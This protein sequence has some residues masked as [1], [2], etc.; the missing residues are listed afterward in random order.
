MTTLGLILS[1]VGSAMLVL[2]QG[3]ALF[4]V[5]R[6]LQ[7]LSVRLHHAGDAGVN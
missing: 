4:L 3:P 5:G 1:I 7:G 2:S 6:V